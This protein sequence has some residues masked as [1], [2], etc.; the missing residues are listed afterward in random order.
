MKPP[1]GYITTAQAAAHLGVSRSTLYRW[2]RDE[3]LPIRYPRNAE[4]GGVVSIQELEQ[5]QRERY[6]NG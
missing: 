1:E 3:G 2:Y 4:R 6:S 5:W